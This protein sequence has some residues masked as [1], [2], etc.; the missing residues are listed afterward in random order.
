[1]VQ[2]GW[3]VKFE[4]RFV[5]RSEWN[6]P[7]LGRQIWRLHT[8]SS[9]WSGPRNRDRAREEGFP[10]NTS[11]NASLYTERTS[12]STTD[13]AF[14]MDETM[15]TTS[16]WREQDTVKPATKR[17]ERLRNKIFISAWFY[18]NR[19]RQISSLLDIH[20]GIT[21]RNNSFSEGWFSS[22]VSAGWKSAMVI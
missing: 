18:V 8:R 16:A 11:N 10:E 2:W 9:R 13:L 7:D 6:T 5:S 15:G 3:R 4:S 22:S 21:S 12:D 17:N 1:M 20:L 19:S 14:G